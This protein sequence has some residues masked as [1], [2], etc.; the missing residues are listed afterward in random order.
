MKEV[1][2]NLRARLIPVHGIEPDQVPLYMN[3]ADALILTS[4][5]EGSPNVIKEAMAC[6]L[7]IVSVD[8]GDV[9]QWLGRVTG[10]EIVPCDDP[11]T[12]ASALERL[13]RAGDRT[14]GWETAQ[15]LDEARMA[16]R[17]ISSLRS[18]S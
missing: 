7:P 10:C 3:A 12:I 13:L 6:N 15:E 5:S 2:P 1:D 17:H 9:R 4:A 14:N 18:G 8:V 11:K 16:E